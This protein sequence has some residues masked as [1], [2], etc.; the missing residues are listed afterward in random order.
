[1]DGKPRV[2]HPGCGDHQKVIVNGEETA[3][4]LNRRLSRCGEAAAV[5]RPLFLYQV[6]EI[7]SAGVLGTAA[8]D[9]GSRH[10][11]LAGP[12]SDSINHA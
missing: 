8:D 2:C 10:P 3:G 1:M 6:L 12:D 5:G 11:S 7:T 9:S 4:H